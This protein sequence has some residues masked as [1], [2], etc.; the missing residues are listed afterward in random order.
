VFKVCPSCGQ[1]Y[2]SWATECTD[3]RVALDF[4]PSETAARAPAPKAAPRPLPAD[5]DLELLGIGEARNLQ[6]LAQLLQEH[7]IPCQID[8]H[9][10]GG[11]ITGGA[12]FQTVR[13][14]LYVG[15]A[16]LV[17]ARA[18]ANRFAGMP[19]DAEGGES[20]SDPNACPACGEPLPENAATCASC[21]L[22]FPEVAAEQ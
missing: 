1:E 11:S 22:E 13:L 14:G 15:R 12:R 18:V 10:R 5:E 9:P 21:G 3:C 20:L 8:A 4:A 19:S 16:D 7:G 6:A 2:Q 17:E